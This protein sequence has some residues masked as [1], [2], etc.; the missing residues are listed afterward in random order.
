MEQK[1]KVVEAKVFAAS[2]CFVFGSDFFFLVFFFLDV[3][4]RQYQMFENHFRLRSVVKCSVSDILDKR[5]DLFRYFS[6][7]NAI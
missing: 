7:K 1:K 6:S 4:P 5:I 2:P 3:F